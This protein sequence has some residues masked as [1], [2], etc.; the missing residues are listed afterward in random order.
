MRGDK[1]MTTGKLS[2][3][4]LLC[5]IALAA[6]GTAY[7]QNMTMGEYEFMNSCATCHG[8]DG[9]GDGSIAGYL[10]TALPDLT[11]LKKTNDGVFP[12]TRVYSFI[13][14]ES[15]IGAHGTR[16]MPA[17]GQRYTMRAADDPNFA[18]GDVEAYANL[19]ILALIEY[20]SQIQEE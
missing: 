8:A 20:L 13:S 19:R 4:A 10:N 2:G 5:G 16:D 14:G 17:W 18:A 9:K 6:G 7:A 12:V 1:T 11:Q 15:A 3:F